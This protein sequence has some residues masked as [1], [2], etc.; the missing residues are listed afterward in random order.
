M[1]Q[2]ITRGQ[3]SAF[4]WVGFC[5]RFYSWLFVPGHLIGAAAVEALGPAAAQ[6]VQVVCIVGRALLSSGFLFHTH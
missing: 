1:G 5:G 3:S 4:F 2:Q 6:L